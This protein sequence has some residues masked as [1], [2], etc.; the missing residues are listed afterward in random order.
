MM[1]VNLDF[2]MQAVVHEQDA[3]GCAGIAGIAQA[4]TGVDQLGLAAIA[5]RNME[6]AID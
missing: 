4:L 5:L 1:A 3:I 2:N 6:R